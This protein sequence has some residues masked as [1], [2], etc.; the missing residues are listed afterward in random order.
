MLHSDL[1]GWDGR[2]GREAQEARDACL[3]KADSCCYTT[4][5]NTK[6]ES[7]YTPIKFL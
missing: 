6:L 4:E 7:G 5:T 1:E 3:L 2:N